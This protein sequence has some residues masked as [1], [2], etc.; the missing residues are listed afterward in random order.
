MQIPV[1]NVNT[2]ADAAEEEEPTYCEMCHLCDRED[3]LLLC[4]GC[5]RGYHLECLTPPL[6]RVPVD[7][8]FCPQCEQ[9]EGK[10]CLCVSVDYG[11]S[12]IKSNK[13]YYCLSGFYI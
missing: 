12:L 8:W 11:L 5:D 1:E 3:R 4:D 13:E 9:R 10:C 7:E 2:Q 6:S